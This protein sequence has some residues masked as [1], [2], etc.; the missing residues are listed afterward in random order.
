MN[1]IHNLDIVRFVTGLEVTRVAAEFGTFSTPVP[2]D[3]EELTC[4]EHFGNWF[5]NGV[6]DPENEYSLDGNYTASVNLEAWKR[7]VK[8]KVDGGD[9][10]DDFKFCGD[11]KAEIFADFAR[12]AKSF[13][14][15]MSAE[16]MNSLANQFFAADGLVLDIRFDLDAIKRYTKL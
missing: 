4:T 3:V 13:D 12:K 10:R 9:N 11:I 16:R 15:E 1:L 2:V 14:G 8:A 5:V 6:E 7:Y